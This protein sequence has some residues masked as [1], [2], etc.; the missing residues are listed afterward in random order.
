MFLNALLSQILE[1]NFVQL[2]GVYKDSKILL[3]L[4]SL[5]AYHKLYIV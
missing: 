5:Q 1:I 4:F 2:I 3:K